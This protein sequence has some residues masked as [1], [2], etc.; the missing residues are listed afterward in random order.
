MQEFRQLR[1]DQDDALSFARQP[2]DD[3]INILFRAHIYAARWIVQKQNVRIDQEPAG[4]ESFL[5]ITAAQGIDRR[6]PRG[7][8]QS[9]L[10]VQRPQRRKFAFFDEETR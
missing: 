3:L 7:S 4:Q 8:L 5:L 6:G 1:A 2:V 10:L 9:K